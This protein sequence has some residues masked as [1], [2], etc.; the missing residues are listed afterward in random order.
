VAGG[1]V[2]VVLEGG[3]RV[4]ED[5]FGGRGKAAEADRSRCYGS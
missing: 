5:F 3:V 1:A 4:K 2:E